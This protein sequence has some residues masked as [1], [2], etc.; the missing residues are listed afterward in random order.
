MGR[1]CLKDQVPSFGAQNSSRVRARGSGPELTVPD[2]KFRAP[3]FMPSYWA[4]WAACGSRQASNSTSKGFHG[5]SLHKGAAKPKALRSKYPPPRAATGTVSAY[6]TVRQ[7][8]PDIQTPRA[9]SL[10]PMA[11]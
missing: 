3:D 10:G 1:D 9:K 5:S 8:V 6:C 2:A 7:A 4:A 11:P